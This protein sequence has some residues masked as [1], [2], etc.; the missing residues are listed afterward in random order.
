MSGYIGQGPRVNEFEEKLSNWLGFKNIVTTNSGTSALQLA[1]KLLNIGP[2]D[3]VVTT[4]MTCTATNWPILD[5]GAAPIWADIN[6]NTGLIDPLDVERKITPRTKAIIV[7][8]WGGTAH[9]LDSLSRI[10]KKYGAVLIEDA[11]HA[12]GATYNGRKI[13]NDT[14]DFTIFSL[15][16][17]KHITTVDGGFL[18]IRDSKQFKR[19]K[20]LRWYGIDRET[21]QRDFRCE[22]DVLEAGM[23]WHMNDVSATIGLVQLDYLDGIL[24]QH[25]ENAAFY[26]DNIR[27]GSLRPAFRASDLGE[28]SFW[29]YTLLCDSE[30]ERL[31]FMHHARQWGVMVSQVHA[32]NDKHTCVAKYGDRPLPGVDKFCENM[33]CIPVHWK[34]LQSEKSKIVDM[35]NSFQVLNSVMI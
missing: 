17:I 8:H 12:I 20:L 15:Q 10:A 31:R 9:D 5:R 7:V 22:L 19:A 32:R 13:G 14:A 2:G 24:K 23:K 27:H 28:S 34:L 30:Q 4:P 26:W 6:P 35:C 16:A 21:E 18:T 3:D 25:R 11:A 29:L 33:V 1:L